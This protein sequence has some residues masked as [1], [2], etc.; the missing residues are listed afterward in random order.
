M[1]LAASDPAL[2]AILLV[3]AAVLLLVEVLTPTLGLLG[4]AALLAMGGAIYIA[5]ALNTW[6][7]ML[8]LGAC[9]L[10]TPTYL[11]FAVK[12]L[13]NSPV[14][15]RLFLRAAPDA[16]ND[17]TPESG[18]L[19]TLIGKQGQA[20]TTLRPSGEVTVDGKRYDARAEFGMIESGRAVK[21]V[22][23]GGTDVVVRELDNAG[24]VGEK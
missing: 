18:E 21:V 3:A 23:A 15:K 2:I 4:A 22:R 24:P 20:A 19:H 7:G 16:T 5:F 14:G 1:F 9:M 17:A 10:G 13:P 8:I 12:L 11:Y 6:L